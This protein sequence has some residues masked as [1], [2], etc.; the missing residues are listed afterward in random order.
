LVPIETNARPAGTHVAKRDIDFFSEIRK[1]GRMVT[2][3]PSLNGVDQEKKV[4]PRITLAQI[5]R[6][7]AAIPPLPAETAFNWGAIKGRG[8]SGVQEEGDEIKF[9]MTSTA[10]TQCYVYKGE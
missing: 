3:K 2:V 10:R 4:P 6:F 7:H 9:R 8:K 1:H 5:L